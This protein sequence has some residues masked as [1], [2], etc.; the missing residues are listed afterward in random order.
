MN[1]ILNILQKSLME[2][3]N[4]TREKLIERCEIIDEYTESEK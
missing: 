3:T 4:K 2:K 1:L